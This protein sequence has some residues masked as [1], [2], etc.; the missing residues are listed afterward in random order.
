MLTYLTDQRV[1]MTLDAGGTN[2]VFSAMQAGNFIIEPI[3]KPSYGH[4]LDKC[5][6]TLLEGF[7][8][9]KSLLKTE[10]VAISFAFPGPADYP[11]G[12]IGDLVNLPAFRG[13]VAL[14]PMLHD[15]FNLPV[16]INNDGDL[17][18]YG[19]ALAGILP[20][21]N[22]D[23]EK[24]GNP[25]RYKNL[26]GITLGTGFGAGIVTNHQLLTG[27]NAAAAEVNRLSNRNYPLM[28]AEEGVSTRSVIL[29]Y[30]EAGGVFEPAL[31]PKD[32]YEIAIGRR[33]GN[34]EAALKSFELFGRSLGD[35][36]ANL[37]TIFDGIIAIGGGMSGAK[38]LYMPIV[39][40]ELKRGFTNRKH[41]HINR[42]VQEVYDYD[43]TESREAFL[44]TSSREIK[45]P[46]TNK[47]IIYDG[48]SRVAIAHSQLGASRAISLGAYV[49]AL[50]NL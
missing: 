3:T 39:I 29:E 44:K 45:I 30:I 42:L 1:V 41:D 4:N 20:Q 26:V 25:K 33:E 36:I 47:T 17:Y 9:V 24:A 40:D 35:S 2:F 22:D 43:Q 18:A 48:V 13:G 12:I 28:S 27:D 19:E 32:I 16:F 34:K 6:D 50:N 38:S 7:D 23:L 21:I 15:H 31:M 11:H 49:F 46:R 14:G 10:P 8:Q 5:L 37:V